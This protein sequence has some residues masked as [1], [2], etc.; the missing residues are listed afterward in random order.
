M[1]R[2]SDF[3]KQLPDDVAARERMILDAVRRREIVNFHLAQIQTTDGLQR[4]WFNVAGDC[5]RIGVPGDSLL[6]S[7]SNYT[8]QLIAD[9]L[10]YVLPTTK[11]ADEIYRAADVKL[12]PRPQPWYS[13]KDGSGDGTMMRTFRMMDY[14]KIV[15]AEV[16]RVCGNVNL[17][18][19]IIA[20]VGKDWVNDSRLCKDLPGNVKGGGPCSCNK[21]ECLLQAKDGGPAAINYGWYTA[22]RPTVPLSC[23][24]D[25]LASNWVMQGPYAAHGI[26]H[27]DYSQVVR[28]IGR[29]ARFCRPADWPVPKGARDTGEVAQL[30][31]G[32]EGKVYEIDIYEMAYDRSIRKLLNKD[33]S[34]LTMRNPAIPWM[35]GAKPPP[36]V[37]GMSGPFGE[38]SLPF[39]RDLLAGA[40]G[41]G[42]DGEASG[43]TLVKLGVMAGGVVVGWYGLELLMRRV[44]ARS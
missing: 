44:K 9:E 30:M 20:N 18:R 4:A 11:L 27:S 6:I 29:A 2:G 17:E 19:R 24:S 23:P 5:L 34:K 25:T 7:A 14:S 36:S 21:E 41:L 31:N 28:L 38:P 15:D 22:P 39:G 32:Q 42:V 1:I 3:F 40:R 35:G 43:N 37:S 33:E 8:A 26:H 16:E 12:T 10:G 13:S